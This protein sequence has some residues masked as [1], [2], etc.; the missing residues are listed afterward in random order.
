M[1]T[2]WSAMEYVLNKTLKSAGAANGEPDEP[3]EGD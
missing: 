3:D 1:E 2:Y